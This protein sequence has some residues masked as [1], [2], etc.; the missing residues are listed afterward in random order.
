MVSVEWSCLDPIRLCRHPSIRTICGAIFR[1]VRVGRPQFS[2][3]CSLTIGL[4]S[5]GRVHDVLFARR[6]YGAGL[7]AGA[8]TARVQMIPQRG[9]SDT[10]FAG[11]LGRVFGFRE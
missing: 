11:D 7:A 4:G 5:R 9:Q 1:S 6:L 3:C 10:Q 8:L 2:R